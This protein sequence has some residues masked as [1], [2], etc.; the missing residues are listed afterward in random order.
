[1]QLALRHTLLR[2]ALFLLL[3]AAGSWPWSV[4]EIAFSRALSAIGNLCF[5]AV[6]IASGTELVLVPLLAT[7]ERSATENV[8]ADTQLVLRLAGREARLGISLRRDAYLPLSIFVAAILVL[9]LERRRK[10]ASL[11][12]GVPLVIGVAI[13]SVANL[14]LFVSSQAPGFAVPQWQARLAEFVFDCWLTPPGNRVIA[15]LFLT[16]GFALGGHGLGSF[17]APRARAAATN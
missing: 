2:A 6:P 10:L 12:L 5:H 4:R 15:P 17:G 1:M 8:D 7:P 16:L 13:A 11:G 9:P 14:A 3:L